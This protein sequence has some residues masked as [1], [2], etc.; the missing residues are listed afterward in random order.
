MDAHVL[1]RFSGVHTNIFTVPR[2]SF[3]NTRDKNLVSMSFSRRSSIAIFL[4]NV[5]EHPEHDSYA[6]RILVP[7]PEWM[8]KSNHTIA[9]SVIT[10]VWHKTRFSQERLQPLFP[11]QHH[12]LLGFTSIVPKS[13]VKSYDTF[14]HFRGK[15]VTR[16]THDVIKVWKQ[17]PYLPHLYLQAYSDN[18]SFISTDTWLRDNNINYYFGFM[19]AKD[20]WNRLLNCGLHL[21]TSEMEGFGHYINEARGIGAVPLIIDGSP[22]NELVNQE[23]GIKI[24]SISSNRFNAGQRYYTDQQQI[25]LAVDQVLG[26]TELEVRKMGEQGQQLFYE[27][28]TRFGA[29]LQSEVS[30]LQIKS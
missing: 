30:R 21:C 20:Y 1:R 11:D 29:R 19:Q 12:V 8:T 13:R 28:Q 27:E 24:K 5:F 22:M 26:M 10:E 25:K 7:N 15:A 23:Y 3:E 16:H 9:Q 18:S 17:N 14:A 2:K 4:E 6:H